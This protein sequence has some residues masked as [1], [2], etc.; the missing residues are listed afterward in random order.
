MIWLIAN[1]T[2]DLER[3]YSKGRIKDNKSKFENIGKKE[4]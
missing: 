3:K 1:K 4:F 2:S